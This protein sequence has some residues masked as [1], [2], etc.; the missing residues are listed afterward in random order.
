[1]S[2]E[3]VTASEEETIVHLVEL[4]KDYPGD[5]SALQTAKDVIGTAV[6]E[7][8]LDLVWDDEVFVDYCLQ[9]ATKRTGTDGSDENHPN[10]KLFQAE[11][12][13]LQLYILG[14]VTSRLLSE[15]V[16]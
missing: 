2:N 7:S 1:M 16:I 10:W 3:F 8:D 6:A 5:C 13:C 12:H 14:K 9:E 15:V 4:V 11:H